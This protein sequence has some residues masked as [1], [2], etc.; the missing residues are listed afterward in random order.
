MRLF[1]RLAVNLLFFSDHQVWDGLLLAL[2]HGHTGEFGTI[3][4][5]N[6][7]TTILLMKPQNDFIEAVFSSHGL[8]TTV[9]YKFGPTTPACYALEVMIMAAMMMMMMIMVTTMMRMIIMMMVM[10]T[11]T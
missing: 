1:T 8:L 6:I 3:G 9:A 7:V 11:T 5:G 4:K 10:M 2:Q